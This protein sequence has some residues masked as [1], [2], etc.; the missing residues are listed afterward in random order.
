MTRTYN[1]SLPMPVKVKPYKHQQEAFD[2]ACRRFGI[3]PTDFRSR[4][5]ALLMEMGCG[6]SLTAIALAGALWQYRRI[7][8]VLV[9]A[10]LSILGVWE[11]E[12]A[13]Y[14]N[15]PY[16]LT[17]LKGTKDKKIK[18][19]GRVA[20]NMLDVKV[21]NYDSARAKGLDKELL[22]YDA[23]LIIADEG[24]KLKENRSKQSIIMH[25]L[26]DK[27]RYKLLLT[28]TL[29]TNKE[30]DVFSEYRFLNT[31]IFG[32]SF[33]AFRNRFF[34]MGGYQQH[35]PIFRKWMLDDFLKRLH[36]IAYRITKAEAL[37]LPDITEEVRTVELEPKAMKIYKDIEQENF[38]YLKNGEISTTNI[39]TRLLRLS[40]A[41]G[42]FLTDDEGNLHQIST[43]KL[44]A[45]EDMIDSSVNEGRK[46]VVIAQFVAELDA[47]R[48]MLIKKKLGY[49]EIR[50]GVNNR[51]ELI[52]QFQTDPDCMVFVGQISA[53]GLGV[54]LTAAS[55]MVFYSMNYN[56]S[57]FDQ[58]KARIHRIGQT[59][60]CHYIFL[61]C[62]GTVDRKVLR[63]LR[64]KIDLAK[65][66]V[67]DY[68]KT[69]QN[70]FH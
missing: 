61:C 54:T 68:R 9:V 44:A 25:Q 51:A 65:L 24:H 29:I 13:Q 14:A 46:I 62:R 18:Q 10:P 22:R 48:D 15:F 5:V 20:E 70:P 6:K 12:F 19:L 8:R 30:I 45:L 69:G 64:D 58:C 39:L 63:S 47:I 34:D 26:G 43:A 17:I 60:N 4:G 41:T 31:D 53:A 36:L 28:G 16:E 11:D 59:E 66:L 57:D 35:T 33:F 42:G 40:Q 3:L 49:V 67:D 27:A 37:D 1:E 52:K 32:S 7:K 38:A 56:M 50:G 2:F 55:T 23:D 21:V